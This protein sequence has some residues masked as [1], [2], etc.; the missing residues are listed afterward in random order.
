MI[1]KSCTSRVAALAALVAAVPAPAALARDAHGRGPSAK[2]IRA[3]IRSAES[4]KLLWATVN[5]CDTK[6][7]PDTIGI[8][9][10]APSLPFATTISMKIRVDYWNGS[11]FVPDPHATKQVALGDPVDEIVQ[12]G[13]NFRFNPPVILSGTIQFEWKLA[14]KVIGRA[15]RFTGHGYKRVA[16][17]DPPG[18]STATCRMS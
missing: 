3:A 5:I 2:A 11:R 6:G 7:H 8:R 14:G 9:G 4:S 1:V 10:Q 18:Y 15:T 16:D 12:N 13:A 17:G